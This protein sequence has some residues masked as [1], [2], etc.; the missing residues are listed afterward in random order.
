MQK[1]NQH[2][3]KYMC[4]YYFNSAQGRVVRKPVNANTGLKVNQSISF[5]CIKM[6]FIA[7]VLCSLGLFN[8]KTERQKM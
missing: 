1:Q 2:Q 7:Y 8:L 4:N 5:S 6:F 3:Q